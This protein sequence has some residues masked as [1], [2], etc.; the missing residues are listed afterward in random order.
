MP[1]SYLLI[2]HLFFISTPSHA[3][4]PQVTHTHTHTP[5]THHSSSFSILFY[6]LMVRLGFGL[7]NML[8][9]AS[10][11]HTQG[12]YNASINMPLS[13]CCS[14]LPMYGKDHHHLPPPSAA[15]NKI[16]HTHSHT[17]TPMMAKNRGGGHL[18]LLWLVPPTAPMPLSLTTSMCTCT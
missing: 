15:K 18:I 10:F 6:V 5:T 8:P 11:H 9:R 7:M 12:L 17:H 16:P 1:D 14:I 13:R 4:T 2:F 3:H